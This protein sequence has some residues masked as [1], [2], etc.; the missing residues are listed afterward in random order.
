VHLNP[1]PLIIGVYEIDNPFLFQGIVND[2]Y[3]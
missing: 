2:I 3:A 1:G